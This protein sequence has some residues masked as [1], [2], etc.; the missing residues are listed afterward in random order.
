MQADLA[1]LLVAAIWGSAFVAQRTAAAQ[2]GPFAFNAARFALGGLILAPFV[3][4]RWIKRPARF[5][6]RGG[7][8]LGLLLFGGATLQQVGL[9]ETTAGKA[10]FI[11]GLYIVIVPLLLA[12]VWRE[13]VRWSNRLGAGMAAAGLFLLSVQSEFQLA[14]GDGWILAGAFVWA[15]HVVAIGRLA[16]GRDPAQL[17]M[18]QYAVCAALSAGMAAFTERGLLANTLAAWPEIAYTGLMSIGLGYTLQVAAQRH[19]PPSHTAILLS[20]EAV[21]AAIFGWILLNETLNARQIIGCGLML[22]G[23]G[24]AQ[25]NVIGRR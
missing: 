14:P 10:G 11:T 19:T 22:A 20:L 3:V 1:L 8:L 7:A 4:R 21:F 2:I 12:L 24:L 25:A 18:T 5:D 15:L 9:G 16:P 6:W 13:R 23:I 17:A